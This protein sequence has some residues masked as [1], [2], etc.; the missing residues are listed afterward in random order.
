MAKAKKKPAPLN[1]YRLYS[2]RED[3]KASRECIRHFIRKAM[4]RKI[5]ALSVS[6]E[7]RDK[8]SLMSN[9]TAI[10]YATK[11]IHMIARGS[12]EYTRLRAW[13]GIREG[14]ADWPW[15][16]PARMLWLKLNPTHN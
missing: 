10:E 6:P 7:W 5:W 15:D 3:R 2:W 9:E 1:H 4:A 13:L 8:A 11:S 12:L 16:R 14:G